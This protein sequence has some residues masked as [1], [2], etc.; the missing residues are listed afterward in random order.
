M[1]LGR[2]Q[3]AV[4]GLPAALIVGAVLGRLRHDAH[5]G[6][7]V[8]PSV[9]DWCAPGLEPIEGGACFASPHEPQGLIVYLHGRYTPET[10]NEELER[11]ARVARLAGARGFSVV[12]FRGK[13]GA[14]I[15]AELAT[16]WCWPSN[17]RTQDAGVET[18]A[19]WD[20]ALR[21]A[22]VRI[23]KTARY[24]LG[25]SNGGYFATLIATRSLLALDAI[26]IVGAGP[27]EPTRALG[28]KTPLLLVT[29]D[30][31]GALDDMLRLEAEL[32]H[33]SWPHVFTSREGRHALTEFDVETALD[34]FMKKK[35][36][37]RRPIR[38]LDSGVEPANDT[39]QTP[40]VV[41]DPDE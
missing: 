35:I 8:T 38:K 6:E 25:F 1:K 12:A 28:P 30:E 32:V 11:Q 26:A 3:L 39:P 24:L 40:P 14:C 33:E 16:Y 37:S 23:G 13:Q 9:A 21:T 34:F 20:L 19:A 31:D 10:Q 2:K 17:E 29:A 18:V 22:E 36:A 7:S 15:G 4:L 41:P 27:V 5:D